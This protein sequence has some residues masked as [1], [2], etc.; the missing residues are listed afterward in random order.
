MLDLKNL[1]VVEMSSQEVKEVTGGSWWPHI[2]GFLD[3]IAGNFHGYI[4]GYQLW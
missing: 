4:F 2:T 1:G 3:G